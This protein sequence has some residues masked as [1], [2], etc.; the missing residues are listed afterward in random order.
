LCDSPPH[1]FRLAAVENVNALCALDRLF[2]WIDPFALC[3]KYARIEDQPSTIRWKVGREAMTKAKCFRSAIAGLVVGLAGVQTFAQGDRFIR[4]PKS[5]AAAV[6]APAERPAT[7]PF[8]PTL[9]V[10]V[11]PTTTSRGSESSSAKY[12]GGNLQ[13]GPLV[14]TKNAQPSAQTSS[15]SQLQW[16]S[17]ANTGSGIPSS[18]SYVPLPSVPTQSTSNGYGGSKA[19]FIAR[20]TPPND[21][22]QQI[23]TRVDQIEA[24]LVERLTAERLEE[25]KRQA[26]AKTPTRGSL[27]SHQILNDP[28]F[29]REDALQLPVG[30]V[31][32]PQGWQAVGQRLTAHINACENLLRRG[33]NYSARQE[34]EN[35]VSLLVRHIDLVDNKF[36]SEP[37][38]RSALQALRESEDFTRAQYTTADKD[39]LRRLIDSHDTSVLK[40]SDLS[41]ISPLIAAQHYQ[42]YATLELASAAQGHPWASELFYAIGRTYQAEADIDTIR[43]DSLRANALTFYRAARTTLPTNA[44]ACNQLGFLLLQLD[45]AEEAREALIAA[46][47]T[48]QDEAYLANLAEASRRLGDRRMQDWA[49]QTVAL[50]RMQTPAVP[51]TPQVIEIA[52]QQ[53]IAL[54][55]RAGGLQPPI[56]PTINNAPIANQSIPIAQP[57]RTVSTAPTGMMR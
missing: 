36:R 20:P 3:R 53:F 6:E 57:T 14:G 38:W 4:Q 8:E 28:K 17:R 39:M 2:L 47:R 49:T 15:N 33:A 10:N 26:A 46:V 43:V 27:I 13:F 55:P 54:S 30:R 19:E 40:D 34:A 21:R 32:N 22:Y 50:R 52:P 7:E 18:N 9:P 42:Q 16:V 41:E 11:Q 23:E 24:K 1:G 35:A 44:V 12:A 25:E 51:E 45:R 56:V 48:K 5:N 29:V 31:E 37:A